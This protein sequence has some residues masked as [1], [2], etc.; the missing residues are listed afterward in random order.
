LSQLEQCRIDIAGLKT[1]YV[2]GGSGPA[3]VLIHGGAPGASSLVSWKL[4]LGAFA[5]AGFSV[6][7]YDQ[8]GFGFSGIPTDHSLEF[9]VTHAAA[10]L[11]A[12]APDRV[13][14]VANSMGAYIAARLALDHAGID[15]LALISSSTL[16]P[17]GSAEATARAEA[18]GDELRG[19]VPSLEAMRAMTCKTLFRQELVTDELVRERYEMSTGPLFDASKARAA[20]RGFRSVA[21]ELHRLRNPTLLLWGANDRGASVERAVLLLEALPRAELHVFNNCAHWVQWDQADRV[22]RLVAD[23]LRSPALD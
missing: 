5:D 13:H 8:P 18:H 2:R 14:L 16:A 17:K 11:A 6:Y 15:R 1:F 12:V 4:N 3:I 10:F 21:G 9:R 23:F 19:Y 7:A 22:N 20:A